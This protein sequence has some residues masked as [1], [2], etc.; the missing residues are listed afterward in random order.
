MEWLDKIDKRFAWLKRTVVSYRETGMGLFPKDWHMAEVISTRFCE[1]TQDEVQRLLTERRDQLEVQ[2]LMFALKKSTEFETWLASRFP[3]R[4][5]EE[6]T[7]AAG[8]KEGGND[9]DDEAMTPGGR[10][11]SQRY[12]KGRGDGG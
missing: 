1:L 4:E 5:W 6:V 10:R 3:S 12:G 9:D 8:E 11:K 2:I 7:D